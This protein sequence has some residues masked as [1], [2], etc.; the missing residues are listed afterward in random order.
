MPSAIGDRL[1]RCGGFT[2]RSPKGEEFGKVVWVRYTSRADCPD[3]L[4]VRASRL[5]G[6][7]TRVA[8]IS[9][10]RVGNVDPSARTVTLA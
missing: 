5:F 1:A 8:E 3:V 4:V 7:R 10:D 6:A 2:V 9:T